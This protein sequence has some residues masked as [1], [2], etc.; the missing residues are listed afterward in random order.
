VKDEN[1]KRFHISLEPAFLEIVDQAANASYMT[2]SQYIRIALLEKLG[3]YNLDG[4]RV[5]EKNADHD[6]NWQE[7]ID[8]FIGR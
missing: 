3:H 5:R 4:S 6:E 1:V 7:L 8:G 2:R